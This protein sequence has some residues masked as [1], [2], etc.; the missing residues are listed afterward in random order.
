MNHRRYD[1]AVFDLDGTLIDSKQDLVASVNAMLAHLDRPP[2]PEETIAS[3]VGNG[4]PVLMRR[5]L[6]TQATD[7]EVSTA[8]DFFI[9]YYHDH[10]TVHTRLYERTG[11]ALYALHE[12]GVRLAVL[13]NKPVRISK[14][15]LDDLG[16]SRLFFQV[17]GG[18]SFPEKKPHPMGLQSLLEEAR[19]EAARA[20]MVGDSAIDVKTARNAGVA[21]CGVAFG[22][23]PDTFA[24]EPPDVLIAHM[25]EL[26]RVVLP[27]LP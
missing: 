11:E 5:A 8:L 24:Q 27:T 18:N 21:A 9:R 14:A 17:Y 10:R 2:L 15:I 25:D 23:Q 3:Y 19:A 16:V 13:T 12:A 1:L 6:G 22:F 4:A 20:L 26:P 7:D